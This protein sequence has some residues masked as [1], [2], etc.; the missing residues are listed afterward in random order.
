MNDGHPAEETEGL[1]SNIF[2]KFKGKKKEEDVTEE[3]MDMVNESHEQ[4][5]LKENEAEM[6]SNIFEFAEKQVSDVMTHRKAIVALD[7]ESTLQEA[8]AC[9]MEENYSRYPVYEGDIDN[10]IGILHI[11]D[12]LKLYIESSDKTETLSQLKKQILYEPYCIPETR[13]LSPLFNEMQKNKIHMAV[14]VDEYG[15]TAGIITMED[16]LEEIVGNIQDEFDEEEE[17]IVLLEDGSYIVDG[18]TPLEDIEEKL[19]I[20][21]DCDELDIDTINGYMIY[22]LGK[23][24]DDNEKFETECKGYLF[25]IHSVDNKM[26]QKVTVKPA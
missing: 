20:K 21:F 10:I 18:Q 14:V 7:C 25:G 3:I 24:P 15:Q 13:N 12:F 26:I 11:R 19:G 23:I 4:G 17:M 1:F 2:K 22:K 5:V 9:V 6:I 8:Y 16:I